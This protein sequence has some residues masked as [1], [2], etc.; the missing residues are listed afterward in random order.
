MALCIE[1]YMPK[2]GKYRVVDV[3]SGTSPGQTA[4]HR[5]LLHEHDCEYTGVDIRSAPNV[6]VV[7]EKPYRLPL[8]TRSADV[9]IAGQVLEHVPFFWASL[10]EIARVLRPNGYLFL[11][12]PSRGHVHG[13]D[14]CWRFYPDALRAMAAFARLELV[15]AHTDFPPVKGRRRHDYA[16]IDEENYYWGDTVGVFRKPGR[17]PSLRIWPVRLMVRWWA[18]R[19]GGLSGTPLPAASPA[20]GRDHVL[21]GQANAGSRRSERAPASSAGW[22]RR[23]LT[24]LRASGR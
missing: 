11:T 14:D 6:D 13:K 10:L 4:T 24:G 22:A 23:L 9:V 16:R 19:I 2:D 18:N 20:S 17:Y 7:M 3:G 15:E 8:R 1:R 21:S 5:E 12:V